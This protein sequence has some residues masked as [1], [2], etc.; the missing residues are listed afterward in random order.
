ME[1]GGFVLTNFLSYDGL[2]A[3]NNHYISL[4][5]FFCYELF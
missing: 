2:F 1:I 3:T 5:T 4:L